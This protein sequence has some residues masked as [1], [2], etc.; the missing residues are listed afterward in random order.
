MYSCS[1]TVGQHSTTSVTQSVT[2][3]MA[4]TDTHSASVIIMFMLGFSSVSGYCL[5][6]RFSW[7]V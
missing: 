6:F 7:S 1:I 2:I 3:S 5:D 4:V